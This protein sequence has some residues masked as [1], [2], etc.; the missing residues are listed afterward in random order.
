MENNLA[1][2]P[3]Q[4][5]GS[6][7]VSRYYIMHITELGIIKAQ[8]REQHLWRRKWGWEDSYGKGGTAPL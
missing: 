1:Y 8:R 2:C 6:E 5:L 4:S 3:A 7:N